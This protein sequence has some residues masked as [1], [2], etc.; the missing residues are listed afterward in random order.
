MFKEKK[1]RRIC[2]PYAKK[3]A[4]TKLIV[5]GMYRIDEHGHLLVSIH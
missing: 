4:F 5:M 3:Q 1:T 2:M